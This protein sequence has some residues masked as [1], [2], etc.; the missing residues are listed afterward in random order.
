[1][2]EFQTPF[3]GLRQQTLSPGGCERRFGSAGV[4]PALSPPLTVP[5]AGGAP[6]LLKPFVHPPGTG[7]L[8]LGA[9]GIAVVV[10]VLGVLW[11]TRGKAPEANAQE[12]EDGKTALDTISVKVVKA[13]AGGLERTTTQ[14]GTVRAFEYEGLSPKVSGF[15][16]NQ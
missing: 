13:Q 3:F 10:V 4:P 5:R 1:M 16:I 8:W 12:Q 14:P 6:A 2:G 9:G 11:I 7:F 15:L